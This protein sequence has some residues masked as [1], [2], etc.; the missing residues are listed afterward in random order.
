MAWIESH[1]E[2]RL[3][4]KTRRLARELGIP[5]AQAIGHLHCL[6]W[7]AM[8]YAQDGDLSRY[9]AM[10]I[11]IGAEWD[12]E[13]E[14][15]LEALI[16][17]RFVDRLSDGHMRLHDWS[18][19]AGRL[20]EHRRANAERMRRMRAAGTSRGS[21]S[22]RLVEDTS[23]ERAE[24]VQRTCSARVALPNQ[25]KPNR[26]EPN[27]TP[28]LSSPPQGGEES[29][30]AAEESEGEPSPLEA[31]EVVRPTDSV[32]G[33]PAE[34]TFGGGT[35]V[36]TKK[37]RLASEPYSPD[38]EAFWAVYPRRVDKGAAWRAW[39]ARLREGHTPGEL[40]SAAR[41][42]AEA[43][44]EMGVDVQFRKHPATFLGP[45][46]PFVEWV[47]GVPEGFRGRADVPQAWHALRAYLEAAED[48][49]P[50]RA[51]PEEPVSDSH[52]GATRAGGELR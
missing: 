31:S 52:V 10:D 30:P 48:G 23:M 24:H 20:I 45:G 46:R 25:T 51:A 50:P 5:L 27:Q 37:R 49:H 41:H 26:T 19:Y 9:D 15:F 17:A 32:L 7:W 1:Q 36:R 43:V 35:P 8:D 13:P 6:W 22:E 28:P 38:F 44:E 40:I 47:S 33:A 34:G 42:Y 4:P 21:E 14:R 18:E 12:G 29:P 2:L 39:R 11:A 3:H 16:D